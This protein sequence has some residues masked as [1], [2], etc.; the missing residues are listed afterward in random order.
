[1]SVVLPQQCRYHVETVMPSSVSFWQCWEMYYCLWFHA[2]SEAKQE[3]GKKFVR[4]SLHLQIMIPYLSTTSAQVWNV[5]FPVWL[6][7]V[8]PVAWVEIINNHQ[9]SYRRWNAIW[10]RLKYS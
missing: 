1:M 7:N 4:I 5:V 9:H 6:T 8:V 3:R 10:T 2:H